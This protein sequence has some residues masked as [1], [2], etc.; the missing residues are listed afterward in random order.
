VSAAITHLEA[1]D[2]PIIDANSSGRFLLEINGLSSRDG[3]G[4]L[5]IQAQS[6]R[7]DP[8][9]EPTLWQNPHLLVSGFMFREESRLGQNRNER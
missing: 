4:S 7:H 8:R 9:R 3:T 6:L 5:A 1:L 2:M